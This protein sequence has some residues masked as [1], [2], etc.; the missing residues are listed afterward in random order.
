MP[1]LSTANDRGNISV[2]VAF[3]V[4]AVCG[5]GALMVDSATILIEGRQLQNGA[6]NTAL[7]TAATCA[8]GSCVIPTAANAG[9]ANGSA[10]DLMANAALCGTATG[11]SPCPPGQ[12]DGDRDDDGTPERRRFNCRPLGATT[13]PYVQVHASTRDGDAGVEANKLQSFFVNAL[14]SFVA[15]TA[16]YNGTTVRACARAAFGTPADLKPELPLSF[17]TCEVNHWVA[18]S[19]GLVAP[20][21]EAVDE[22]TLYAHSN[23]DKGPSECPKRAGSNQDGPGGFGW[24]K[25]VDG[26][27]SVET[28]L[29][30]GTEKEGEAIPKGCTAKSFSDMHLTIVNIPIFKQVIDGTYLLN[31]FQPFFLTGYR[32]SGQ[33]EFHAVSPYLGSV[34]CNQPA[35]KDI[36]ITGFFVDAPL[37]APGPLVPYTGYGAVAVNLVG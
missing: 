25:T 35:S 21:Y 29:G 2:L 30:N 23:G 31:G 13:A 16:E 34:P 4:L 36:C 5:V 8:A 27:C 18:K 32:L 7:E 20:P 26:T 1:R 33:K 22:A 15:D 28:T 37:I 12:G 9:P 3:F 19:G 11:L 14:D 10:G 24:L 6:E 17:S